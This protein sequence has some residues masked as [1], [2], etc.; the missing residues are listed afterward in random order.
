MSQTNRRLRPNKAR[1]APFDPV[2]PE[3][4]Q[5]RFVWQHIWRSYFWLVPRGK[6]T[7]TF[8]FTITRV[9]MSATATQAAPCCPH[10]G[11]QYP[12]TLASARLASGRPTLA[13]VA[14]AT[15]PPA[16]PC[17]VAAHR[18]RSCRRVLVEHTSRLLCARH[19][20]LATLA[21]GTFAGVAPEGEPAVSGSAAFLGGFIIVIVR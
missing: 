21:S 9:R 4:T 18:R 15:W 6:W 2:T 14:V 3:S 16:A 7:G 8:K 11:P 20:A 12:C 17:A 1:T 5:I 10:G 13:S 19:S